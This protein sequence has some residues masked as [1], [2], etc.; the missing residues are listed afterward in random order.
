MASLPVQG[1]QY[2]V[3]AGDTLQKI[4]ARAYGN[5]MKWSS[6][7]RA[8]LSTLRSKNADL[9]YPGESLYIPPESEVAEAKAVSKAGRYAGRSKGEYILVMDGREV[10]VKQGRFSQGIDLMAHSWTAEIAWT[11][12]ADPWLDPR[13]RRRSFTESELYLGAE[14]VAS[15]R[16]YGSEPVATPEGITRNLEFFSKTA[17]LIDSS[18]STAWSEIAGV[19]LKQIA[20]EIARAL[21]YGLVFDIPAGKAF[22]L[23]QRKGNE[24]IG[25]YLQ[26]LAAQRSLL[27]TTD[28][29]SRIVFVQAITSGKPM[30]SIEFGG[31]VSKEFRAKFDD[32]QLYASYYA[33]G[34]SG[35][36]KP[37]ASVAKDPGVPGIRQLI[38]SAD[39]VD[40]GT[41][42]DAAAWR[43]SKAAGDAYSFPFPVGDWYAPSG[44]RWKPNTLI[45][46]RSAI[47]DIPEATDFV[48]RRV[49][50]EYGPGGRSAT[51]NL[52]PPW[53]LAGKE[54]PASWR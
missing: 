33:L 39:E 25:A 50:F 7:Y 34:Q 46:A 3:A 10:P 2:V 17:D 52:T 44:E 28:A 16:L 35:D 18:L 47:L 51:L 21:G 32:R 1:K 24:K 15:G 41:V 22:D 26:R 48:I 40:A 27:V 31:T 13:I 11:P 14:L 37:V 4:S 9:I 30:A 54:P 6:I 29:Q 5:A 36:G 20:A 43:R 53:A 49:E 38:F 8:N 19:T 45:T 12:G 23:V 42:S